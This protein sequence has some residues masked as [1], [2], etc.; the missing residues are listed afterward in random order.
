MKP[1]F[2][3][4]L[5]LVLV[6]C[7]SAPAITPAPVSADA[8][9]FVALK[10]NREIGKNKYAETC[11]SCHGMSG[12]VSPGAGKDL[13]T[14]AFIKGLS[15]ADLVLFLTRGRGVN[16]PLNTFKSEMPARGGDSA[17]TDQ[18]LADIV[19][20]VRTLQK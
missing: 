9:K 20:Y 15:D 17:L 12:R 1:G 4:L 19:A 5:L 8:Q 18:D 2:L 13:A 14:S 6:A 7:E 16:D 3:M 11:V 10:G